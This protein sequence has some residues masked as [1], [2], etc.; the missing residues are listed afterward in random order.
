MTTQL[1]EE[2]IP[3]PPRTPPAAVLFD[4]DGTLVESEHLWNDAVIELAARHGRSIPKHVLEHTVGIPTAEFINIVHA[5]LKWDHI[6]TA[7]S[8]AWVEERVRQRFAAGLAWRPGAHRLLTEVR[9]AG[10]PTALVTATRRHLVEAA[11]NTL[12][13]HNFDTLVCG[14]EVRH[15]KPHPKPYL[16]AADRLG[17]PIRHCVAIEDSPV[18]VTS[19]V[20]AGC[21]VLAVPSE[22]D[23]NPAELDGHARCMVVKDLT[24]IDLDYLA[25]LVSAPTPD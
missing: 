16:V 6:D 21:A 12:G 4:L 22:L 3:A 24:D 5:Y 20:S 19:A 13:R 18:G 7:T 10:I 23:I 25:W 9:A 8:L 15:G 17:V 14:D 2:E 1:N 11:L